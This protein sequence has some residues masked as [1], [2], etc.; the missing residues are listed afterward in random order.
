MA[1]K[2]TPKKKNTKTPKKRNVGQKIFRFIWKA[3]L[4]FNII[5]V[6]FVLL[7]KFVPVPFTPL[8]IIRAIEQK[9][10]GKEM[11]CSHDW[12]PIEQISPNLQ[13]AV[14]SSEDGKFLE[15]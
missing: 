9:S 3:L 14:I 12:V 7:Y 15:H 10:D 6:F 13:K 11:T 5:S 1:K 2:I 8:M 4:W